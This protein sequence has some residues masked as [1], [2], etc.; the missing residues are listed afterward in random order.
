[1][2]DRGT[3]SDDMCSALAHSCHP[4]DLMCTN[5]DRTYKDFGDKQCGNYHT[6]TTL[7]LQHVDLNLCGFK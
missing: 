2:A 6:Y 3:Q 1:M 4:L 5:D 7:A